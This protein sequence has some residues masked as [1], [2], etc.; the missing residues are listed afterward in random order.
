MDIACV[1][2]TYNRLKDLKIALNAYDAQIFLPKIMIVVN[3]CSNDG[4]REYLE[5]WKNESK[6]YS[7]IVVHLP[8][9]IGGSG[10]FFEGIKIAKEIGIEW[11][12]IADD[13]AFPDKNALFEL[14]K[15]SDSHSSL[16]EHTVALCSSIR[17]MGGIVVGHRRRLS[18]GKIFCKQYIPDEKE[19]EKDFFKI[20]L[21]TYVGSMIRVSAINKVGLPNKEF[22]IYFDDIEHSYRVNQCG[23][24]YV[25]P[26]SIVIH[27]F[28][29][30]TYKFCVDWKYYCQKRNCTYFYKQHYKG[31]Y[32]ITVIKNRGKYYIHKF[33]GKLSCKDQVEFDA[34][35]D[36]IKGN[37]GIS[38][39]YPIGWKAK[40]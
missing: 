6:S 2:V 26:K 37:L 28:D 9:N 15:F 10:G 7:K 16:M 22:F 5:Q 23:D 20:N 14:K 39:R 35:T 31:S 17:F 30:S 27:G 19:Y 25:I 40:N 18:S 33:T 38:K 32:L 12:W 24:I 13:D 11:C 8:K 4:T 34:V 29:A 36:A 21:F 3:N 1:L